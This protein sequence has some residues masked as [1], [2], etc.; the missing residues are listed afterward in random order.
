VKPGLVSG[1][2]VPGAPTDPPPHPTDPP[3]PPPT[4]PPTPA[5]DLL[6]LGPTSDL[7]AV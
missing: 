5:S 4:P 2:T 1:D 3:H 6:C 7:Y